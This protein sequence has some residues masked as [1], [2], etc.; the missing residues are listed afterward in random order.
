V[1]LKIVIRRLE[2][3]DKKGGEIDVL[4]FSHDM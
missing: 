4:V 1:F 3:P 2:M